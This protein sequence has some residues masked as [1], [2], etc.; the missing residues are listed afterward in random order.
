MEFTE[1]DRYK[2][3]FDEAVNNEA[4]FI[5]WRYWFKLPKLTAAEAARLL[6]CLEP[7]QFKS[8]EFNP[9]K[10]DTSDAR[11]RAGKMQRMAQREGRADDTAAG[12]LTWAKEHG[13]KV[14][15]SFEI[16][17]L[18]AAQASP[19]AEQTPPPEQPATKRWTDKA[20]A[21]LKAYRAKHGTKKAA[22]HFDISEALV[23]R[24]LP[25]EKTPTATPFSGLGGRAK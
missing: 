16:E 1:A 25:R 19:A 7:D 3:A 11:E 21:E 22:E 18:D 24:L 10:N 8:L 6:C 13:F 15:T 5:D 2:A 9:G 12:W 14:S 23:R 4:G 20:L 17:L